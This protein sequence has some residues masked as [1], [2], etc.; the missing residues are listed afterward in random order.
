[1][2]TD[3]EIGK[4]C[5]WKYKLFFLLFLLMNMLLLKGVNKV[6]KL[7]LQAFIL[8]IICPGFSSL[9]MMQGYTEFAVTERRRAYTW[10]LWT[11]LEDSE[12][13]ELDVRIGH[14]YGVESCCCSHTHFCF[15]WILPWIWIKGLLI[16]RSSGI[17]IHQFIRHWSV[18]Y[19]MECVLHS[20]VAENE[21][22][23]D[24]IYEDYD[25]ID[26]LEMEEMDLKWQMAMLPWALTGFQEYFGVDEVF[27]LSTPSVFYSDPVEKEVKPLYSRFVKAGEMHVVPP[28]ITGTYMPSPYQSD[29]EETQV[30]TSLQTQR[31]MHPVIQASRPRPKTSHRI[32]DI[33]TLPDTAGT[34]VYATGLQLL[35]ELLLSEG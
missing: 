25:Q 22:D 15:H 7:L 31:P 35:E 2:G 29:I 19:V 1:M 9:L 8:K 26:Q 4:R 33:Q 24:M 21:Q 14:S 12:S 34:K 10:G 16:L 27:D 11:G 28:P 30:M 17:C 20:F 32:V 23:Q 3:H 5:K 13:L 6:R 18:L